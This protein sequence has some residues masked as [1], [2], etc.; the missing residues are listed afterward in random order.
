MMVVTMMANI[1]T[2]V[3]T[4]MIIIYEDNNDDGIDDSK[5]ITGRWRTFMLTLP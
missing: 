2:M 1:Y 5:H 3:L 4:I